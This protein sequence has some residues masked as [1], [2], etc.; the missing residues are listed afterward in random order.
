MPKSKLDIFVAI[1]TG[2]LAIGFA[3]SDSDYV[4]LSKED[5][6]LLIKVLPQYKDK[7]ASN[8]EF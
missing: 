2:L 6:E 7:I 3:K 5:V 4:E 8:T 1:E